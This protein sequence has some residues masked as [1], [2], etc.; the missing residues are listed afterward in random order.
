MNVIK[1][2]IDKMLSYLQ[3]GIERKQY[4]FPFTKQS[5]FLYD[6]DDRKI[7]AFLKDITFASPKI[8]IAFRINEPCVPSQVKD[9]SGTVVCTFNSPMSDRGLLPGD[10]V[11]INVDVYYEGG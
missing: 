8:T 2:T 4:L 7:N 3:T 11:E 6:I 1:D 9:S 5:L 10:T